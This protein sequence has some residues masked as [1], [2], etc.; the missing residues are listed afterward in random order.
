MTQ[1]T[2]KAGILL[3]QVTPASDHLEM[4]WDLYRRNSSTLGFLPR[5]ALDQFAMAGCV[6][7]ATE[8]EQLIGYVAWRRTRQEAVVVHLCV[9]EE[10]RGS[11]CADLLM[12]ALI[13][14][15]VSDPAIRL[16][17]RK[18]YLSANHI[19]PK[20]GFICEREDTG[21]GADAAPL[22]VWRR[23]G[24]EDAPILQAIREASKRPSRIVAI[25]ANVFFDLLYDTEAHHEE[26]KALVA[27]WLD[28]V[29]ICITSE[30]KNEIS[31]Q[32]DM[33]KRRQASRLA[34]NFL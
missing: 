18:D 25:D 32:D 8:Q 33:D 7:A 17:C 34:S 30:L 9:R 21:R 13:K 4:I 26:S 14:E 28:D 23:A 2:V 31:R 24:N 6:I 10:S 27:D 1:G 12:K 22:Y 11:E 20:H 29:D 19:W 16:R 5:G 15:C 3:L